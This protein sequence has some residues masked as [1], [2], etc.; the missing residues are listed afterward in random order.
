MMDYERKWTVEVTQTGTGYI[1]TDAPQCKEDKETILEEKSRVEEDIV[2]SL[3]Y[4]VVVF[5]ISYI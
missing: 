2:L 1:G 5:E 3:R 4:C